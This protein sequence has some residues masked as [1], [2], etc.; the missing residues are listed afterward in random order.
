M[1]AAVFQGEGRIGIERVSPPQVP[2][3]WALVAVSHVGICGTDLAILAGQHPRATPPLIMGHEVSGRLVEGVEQP[4]PGHAS[5]ET[6]IEA[7]GA[8][9]VEPLVTCGAC[10]ACRSGNAHVCSTLRLFGI[11]FPGGMAELVAVPADRVHR[12]PEPVALD[13]GALVEPLAV[14][15]HAVRLSAFRPGDTVA[16][17]GGGPVGLLTAHVLRES[18]A[19]LV[20]VS[21]ANAYR[22]RVAGELGFSALDASDRPVEHILDL[23]AGE[24]AA[25]V[26]DAAGHPDVAAQLAAVCR[27]RG[28]L[29]LVG[30]YKKPTPLDLQAVAFKELA[31]VGSRVYTSNDFAFARDLAASGRI[32][33]RPL[34]SHV[35]PL[36]RAGEGFEILAAGGDA[37]KVLFRVGREQRA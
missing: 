35:L 18:G 26:F 2:A 24:G 21:E 6:R 12:L 17:L 11:D 22:L 20:I 33:L 23:T 9:A 31:L 1:L 36:E 37:L 30:I 15:V 28:Q 25:V 14:A 16:V 32:D 10:S 13:T 3:G 8:V 5:G 27:I 7:G 19:R 4:G 29:V 34:I